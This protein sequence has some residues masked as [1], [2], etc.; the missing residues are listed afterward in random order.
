MEQRYKGNLG[1]FTPEEIELLHTKKICVAGCGALG[2]HCLEQLAR[3]GAGHLTAIDGDVFEPANL[4]RQLL[5][6]ESNLG[7]PKAEAAKQRL[8][9]VNSLVEI[10]ARQVWITAQNAGQLLAGHDVV[11]D[12]S[13]DIK[14]RRVLI[15][16]CAELRIPLVIGAL[17]GWN[18]QVCVVPPGS[19]AYDRL[20]PPDLEP[21]LPEGTP[22]FTPAL[23]ASLQVSEALKLLCG[24]GEALADRLLCVDLLRQEYGVVRLG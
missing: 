5:A 17:S 15:E 3:L 1:A 12:T 11:I 20:C 21:P 9:R 10:C 6:L 7:Q 8:A 23:T 19:G 14:T 22:A 4:N 18:A 13:G 24:K 2:G 16:A